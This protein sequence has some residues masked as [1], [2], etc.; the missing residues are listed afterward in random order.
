M[1]PSP[2]SRAP[3]GVCL[4]LIVA[5]L[6]ARADFAAATCTRARGSH[7]DVLTSTYS[8]A[9]YGHVERDAR[10]EYVRT[11]VLPE[12]MSG[13]VRASRDG[14]VVVY[15]ATYPSLLRDEA[16]AQ[17]PIVVRVY[18]DGALIRELRLRDVATAADL[19]ESISHVTFTQSI[20]DAVVNDQLTLVTRTGRRVTI[21][22]RAPL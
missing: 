17:N 12:P 2:S 13:D 21:D 20:D 15:L 3:F 6:P 4:A 16:L 18:R 14:N 7:V 1:T 8:S 19:R 11:V 9:C 22:T 5:A 10:G